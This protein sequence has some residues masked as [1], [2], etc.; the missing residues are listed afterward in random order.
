MALLLFFALPSALAEAQLLQGGT[1]AADLSLAGATRT[2]SGTPAALFANP[3]GLANV[4]ARLLFGLGLVAAS[5]RYADAELQSRDLAGPRP[6]GY[7]VG[8]LPLL[9]GGLVAALAY[10]RR[11]PGFSRHGPAPDENNASA[12]RYLGRSTSWDEHEVSLA[13]AGSFR[14]LALGASLSAARVSL[15]LQRTLFAGAE[16]DLPLLHTRHHDVD[17]EA[18]LEGLALTGSFGV[19]LT[20]LWWMRAAI[21]LDLPRHLWLEGDAAFADPPSYPATIVDLELQAEGAK[22][23]LDSPWRLG[24]GLALHVTRSLRLFFE[25]NLLLG[26]QSAPLTLTRA[27]W[28]AN[29]RSVAIPAL[30]L[31][32]DPKFATSWRL[33][34]ELAVWGDHLR[35]RAGWAY[36][37][38]SYEA[39]GLGALLFDVQRH[40][41]GA[42]LVL[43]AQRIELSLGFKHLFAAQLDLPKAGLPVIAPLNEGAPIIAPAGTVDL[44]RTQLALEV[45]IML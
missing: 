25:L 13:L 28:I 9:R 38:G 18:E 19:T 24:A 42:G 40:E 26:G 31:L 15:D 12:L 35:L 5:A 4:D 39:L 11:A 30:D 2:L 36:A 45:E 29:G 32:P 20:P 43:R 21:S 23:D 7:A 34:T 3:A 6:L 33:A 37:E 10:R 1:T 22:A 17:L 16:D 8:T 44:S 41:I 14:W 27:R